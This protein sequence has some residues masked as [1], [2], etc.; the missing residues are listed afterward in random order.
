MVH[1]G[2]G[3]NGVKGALSL[4]P[5][6]LLFQPASARYGEVTFLLRDVRKARRARASPVL[7]LSLKRPGGPSL[8]GFYFIKPP[9]LEEPDPPR[10]FR[11]KRA[12][13]LA[14]QS[15]RSANLDKKHE[16]AEWV[17][18]IRLSRQA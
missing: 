5:D 3:L 7:E 8:V 13:R 12:K 1:A 2:T 11:R 6:R 17:D 4:H 10:L 14:A 18:A 15:L 9:S 16:V